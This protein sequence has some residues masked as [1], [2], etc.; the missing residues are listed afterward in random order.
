MRAPSTRARSSESVS[1]GRID[2]EGAA[3]ALVSAERGAATIRGGL[4][5]G[6]I[7]TEELAMGGGSG[8]A[9]A[10]ML[11]PGADETG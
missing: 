6:A 1:T 2:A 4:G 7:V 10:T 3:I 8:A 5:E 11:G 9:G